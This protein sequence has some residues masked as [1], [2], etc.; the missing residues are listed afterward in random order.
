MKY[1]NGYSFC[2]SNDRNADGSGPE[3]GDVY[4]CVANPP[5]ATRDL[6]W[7]QVVTSAKDKKGIVRAV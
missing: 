4:Y 3:L 2:G 1:A 7:E 6:E 5:R